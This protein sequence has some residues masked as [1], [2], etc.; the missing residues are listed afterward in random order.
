MPTDKKI[1]IIIAF[2][3]FRDEEYFIPLQNFNDAGFE[4]V[5]ASTSLATA[6]GSY[7]GEANVDILIEDLD[8]KNFDAIVFVGGGGSSRN[9][10]KGL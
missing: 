3:D 6:L 9:S 1:A 7:G 10:G 4:T 5:T 2:K 8:V